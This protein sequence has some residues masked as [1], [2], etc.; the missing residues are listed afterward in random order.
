MSGCSPAAL[1]GEPQD[2]ES[3]VQMV[4]LLDVHDPLP[5]ARH[6]HDWAIEAAAIRPG[7]QLV[8]PLLGTGRVPLD[9]P[10]RASPERA[11]ADIDAPGPDSQLSLSPD[12]WNYRIAR[13]ADTGKVGTCYRLPQKR[14][15]LVCSVHGVTRHSPERP[16]AVAKA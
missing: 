15:S 14:L 7:D 13:C 12:R 8:D 2:D 6:L 1:L 5:A 9:D 10:L 16:R 4:D 11:A 3:V